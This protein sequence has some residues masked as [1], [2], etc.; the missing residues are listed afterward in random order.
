M[1]KKR[2]LPEVWMMWRKSYNFHPHILLTVGIWLDFAG[3]ISL[4]IAA[5]LSKADRILF[6]SLDGICLIILVLSF[7]KAAYDVWERDTSKLSL[8]N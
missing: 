6:I 2:F 4:L 7:F 8:I 3:F 1:F 5:I